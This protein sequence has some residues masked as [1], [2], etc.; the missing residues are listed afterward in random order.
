MSAATSEFGTK[1]PI[2]DV[3]CH[4]KF[5]EHSGRLADQSEATRLTRF[6][7]PTGMPHPVWR[8]AILFRRLAR[9]K[10]IAGAN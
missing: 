6:G 5:W 1:L 3:R 4:G 9:G 2:R 10:V 7:H 8:R